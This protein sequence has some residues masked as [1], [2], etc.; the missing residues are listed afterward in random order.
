MQLVLHEGIKGFCGLTVFVVVIAAL[1]EHVGDLLIGSA[2]AGADLPDALQQLIEVILAEGAAILHHFVVEDEALLDVLFER[3][4][5]PLTEAGGLFG[6]DPVAHGN[7]GVEI[8]VLGLIVL[9]ICG[10]CRDFL[11]N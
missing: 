4:R 11:G 10:S 6:V 5:R 1:L 2:L 9:P 8:V 3:F 7:D